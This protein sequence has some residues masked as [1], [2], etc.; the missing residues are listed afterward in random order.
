MLSKLRFIVVFVLAQCTIALTD[1]L[2]CISQD[3]EN[4]GV[5]GVY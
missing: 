5:H 4:F 1:N 2:Q 3:F